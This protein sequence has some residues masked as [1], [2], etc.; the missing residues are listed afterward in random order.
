MIKLP[1]I[2]EVL[3][4]HSQSDPDEAAE[5]CDDLHSNLQWIVEHGSDE[6]ATL[7][8]RLLVAVNFAQSEL[9]L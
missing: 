6:Q 1:G 7:A 2:S 5:I 4:E 3:Y 9:S 8:K